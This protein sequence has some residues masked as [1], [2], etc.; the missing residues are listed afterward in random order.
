[1]AK[2]H[3]EVLIVGGGAAGITVAASLTRRSGGRSLSIAIVDPSDVH[4]YQPA[5]TLVGAGS[6]RLGSTRRMMRSLIPSGVDW[7]QERC[8]TFEPENNKIILDSGSA[9]SY[10]NLVV[11]TG[12]ELIWDKIEGLEDTLGS[13]GVCSNY[14][15]GTVEY[16]WECLQS[17]GAGANAVFTQA[18]LPFKCPGAPQKIV[19]LTADHLRKKGIADSCSITF[20]LHGPAIFGVPYFAERLVK[21]AE[22]YA[23][24]LGYQ[25]NLV[26]VDGG[27]K[28]ATFEDV[29]EGGGGR[30]TVD[31]DMLH[32]TPH[33]SPPECVKASPLAN[34]AGFVD[35]DQNSM[36][37]TRF[38]NVFALGDVG[39][40]PNS[41][42]AAAVRKQ[43]PVVVTNLL[44]RMAGN[45][46]TAQYDGYGSCPL[47][48]AYGKAIIA[49]FVYGGKVTPTPPLNPA[50]ESMPNWM[51]KKTGLPLLYW[52][53]M[54]KG[55]ET[56]PAHNTG[57]TE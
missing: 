29:S 30:D 14:S 50:S 20:N 37:S 5:F 16:T 13:N 25:R 47:T 54:L 7:I 48:T 49:E 52:N 56:F 10:D 19:Y 21:V 46:G 8:A 18:P 41:K 2:D 9:L 53:Y 43:A 17:L 28:K 22:R 24:T 34:D 35:V 38:E 42:T 39:S 33:Q 57:W 26:A 12:L 11:C 6:C 44:A 27:A 15:P 45:T 40:T 55:H 32:V 3:Y 36:Q 4:Y 51:I 23:V 1:M 31:F